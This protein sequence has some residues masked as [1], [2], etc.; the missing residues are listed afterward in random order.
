MAG[1]AAKKQDMQVPHLNRLPIQ[2]SDVCGLPEWSEPF[3]QHLNYVQ[4]KPKVPLPPLSTSQTYNTPLSLPCSLFADLRP[5]FTA[6]LTFYGDNVHTFFF[7]P[8]HSLPL[9]QV[10]RTTG[11]REI[12]VTFI[13][14]PRVKDF[15]NL[16]IIWLRFIAGLEFQNGL[17]L[18]NTK[19]SLEKINS[20]FLLIPHR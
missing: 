19:L 1:T 7:F 11:G 15:F 20:I 12:S 10:H 6:S 13:T 5:H 17:F 8:S 14:T 3:S 4:T 2:T 9:P 16:W 18:R